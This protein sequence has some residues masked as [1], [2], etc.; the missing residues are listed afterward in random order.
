MK[1][2]LLLSLFIIN[3]FCYGQ[4]DQILLDTLGADSI[5]QVFHNNGQLFFQVPYHNGKQNGW[6]EQYHE[7]GSVWTK[8]FRVNGKT[9]DGH[10]YILNKNGNIY[11]KGFYKDGHQIGKWYCFTDKGEP[12]KIYIYNK[13]GK[14]IK[15]KVWNDENQKWEKSGLY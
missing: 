6:Y 15:Q 3:S 10:Y 14:W 13:K 9:V 1:L 12:F 4:G 2:T 11:Q 7:N 8:E 5:V